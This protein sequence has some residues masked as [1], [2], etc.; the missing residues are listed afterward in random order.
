VDYRCEMDKYAEIK[1]L[2]AGTT[3]FLLAPG[4]SNSCYAS[5]IRSIDL[6]QNDLGQ[7]KIQTSISVPTESSAQSVCNNF[8]SG[9]TDAYMVHIAEGID[10]TARNEFATLSSRA[11]G[12]LLSP[13][14]TIVHGTALT[15]TEFTTMATHGMRLVWSPKSNMFLY[16]DT[17][18]IDLA[19]QAGVSTIALAPDWALGGSINLLDEL[20]FADQIDQ[21]KFGDILTPAR[22]FQ[23]VTLDAAR[24]LAVDGLL[25]SLQVGKRADITVIGGY[26]GDPYNALLLATPTAVRLVM[27]D[28]RALYGDGQLIGA[29][30]SSPG[31]EA[32]PIC[33]VSKFLCIAETSTLNKL[34]Q[35]YANI[36][37][38]LVD[39]LVD[40]DTN[41]IPV[42]V[43]PFSPIAPLTHCP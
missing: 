42:T 5:V 20:R 21:A 32:V 18:R 11:G 3:S 35:T 16:N 1:A 38:I 30:P 9:T 43:S 29:G 12:C 25:G 7:D 14:T 24:A 31:C 4:L 8:A 36:L 19:I 26:P 13:K 22:L 15:S 6:P 34:D 28:G 37:Q 2:I 27:V 17:A 41:V 39:A 40:Y 10:Q 23:M 33:G